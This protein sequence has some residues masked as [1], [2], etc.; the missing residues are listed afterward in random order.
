[1]A[2]DK[3]SLPNLGH[4]IGVILNNAWAACHTTK[5][6]ERYFSEEG[7]RSHPERTQWTAY[8]ERFAHR[9]RQFVHGVFA[10]GHYVRGCLD[11]AWCGGKPLGDEIVL[12]GAVQYLTCLLSVAIEA[13]AQCRD[14]C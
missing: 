7:H 13:R 11:A 8:L 10:L 6:L 5:L 14:Q 3:F 4:R 2:C 9:T 12:P 1:M